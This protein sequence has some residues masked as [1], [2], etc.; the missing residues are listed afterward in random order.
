MKEKKTRG[1]H[2]KVSF[3]EGTQCA[4]LPEVPR[5]A[6]KVGEGSGRA[7]AS[8]LRE[9]AEIFC[10][11]LTRVPR[12]KCVTTFSTLVGILTFHTGDLITFMTV[13]RKLAYTAFSTL[14]RLILITILVIITY[15]LWFLTTFVLLLLLFFF[16]LS[17]ILSRPTNIIGE[18]RVVSLKPYRI[19][20]PKRPFRNHKS[21]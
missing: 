17:F 16:R 11:G 10:L 9:A 5:V 15:F 13:L 1:F 21:I 7:A 18:C 6:S 14:S 19:V 4:K 2:T 3:N 8:F 12:H 20:S